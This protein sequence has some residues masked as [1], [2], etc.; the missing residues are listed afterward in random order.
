MVDIRKKLLCAQHPDTLRSI[1][2]FAITYQNQ[3]RW[4]EVEQLKLGVLNTRKK[5]GMP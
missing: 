5:L 3:R 1:A 2:N 4:N